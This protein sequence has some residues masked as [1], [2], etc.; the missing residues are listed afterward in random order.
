[1]KLKLGLFAFNSMGGISLL[2]KNLWNANWKEIENLV[3][4]KNQVFMV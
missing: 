4:L 1:M 2:K 3:L